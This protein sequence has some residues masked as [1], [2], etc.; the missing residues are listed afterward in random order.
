MEAYVLT[1]L[2]VTGY[3]LSLNNK[4]KHENIK[5][6]IS[7]NEIPSMNNIY[8]SNHVS[9][10]LLDDMNK[11]N[12]VYHKSLDSNNTNVIPIN[13]KEIE[14]DKTVYSRLADIPMENKEFKHNNMVPFFGG[15]ITQN[16]KTNRT[17][18]RL[19]TFTG[20]G[21]FWKPKQEVENFSNITKDNIYGNQNDNEFFESREVKST[22]VTNYLPFEQEKVGPGLDQG[23]TSKPS[24]GL[25][26]NNKREFE[27]PKTV[28]ELRVKC[29]PKE[30]Y[31]GRVVDG[32]KG[33]LP[34]EI[35]EVCKNRV[36]KF[37]EQT[38]DMYLK[39]GNSSNDKASQ[40]PCV[41][42][43]A[44]NRATTGLKTEEGNVTSIVKS[45]TAPILDIMKINKKEYTVMNGRPQGNLQSSAPPKLTIYDPNDVA[46]TTIK[47]TTIHDTTINNLTGN[48]RIIAYDPDDVAKTTMKETTED[49]DRDG[50]VG[51][52]QG[53]DAYKTTNTEA[54]D[55]DRQFT[56]NNQYYG[57][58]D[59]A[60]EKEMSYDDMYNATIDEVKDILFKNRKPTKTSVKLYNEIDNMNVNHKNMEC[61]D[62]SERDTNNYGRIAS[63][64][65][66][67]NTEGDL[68]HNKYTYNNDNR[69]NPDILSPLKN[70]PYAKPLN[71]F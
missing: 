20:T 43:K 47:E 6:T 68:T 18:E 2:G 66:S 64:I 30:T 36:D 40:R 9:E 63:E 58:G 59:S 5:N 15:K 32:Q 31:E 33:K 13:K 54:K 14:T 52:V 44:T 37:F 7:K 42:M 49:N 28:D 61:K 57:I 24:G 10:T 23:Y 71:V 50:N 16:V 12:R 55:T 3:M 8:S 67:M 48:K 27:L 11:N 41:D 21:N 60:T 70:N 25:Q 22:Y 65:P 51:N 26:Q 17:Q 53:A 29:N 35:G 46:R 19:D 56:S 69:I 38:E 4:N 45:I 39:S 34:G 62:I 1:L